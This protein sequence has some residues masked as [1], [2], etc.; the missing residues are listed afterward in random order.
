MAPDR[1]AAWAC[2]CLWSGG[3]G[4]RDG[5]STSGRWT[6]TG[7]RAVQTWSA[8]C[9]V[10]CRHHPSR[11][12]ARPHLRVPRQCQGYRLASKS[13]HRDPRGSSHHPHRMITASRGVPVAPAPGL[14]SWWQVPAY[15]LAILAS[16]GFAVAAVGPMVSRSRRLQGGSRVRSAAA[17]APPDRPRAPHLPGRHRW[18]GSPRRDLLKPTT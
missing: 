16:S 4:D 8:A 9:E 2:N 6:N 17:G 7:R 11:G 14:P 10:G 5:R 1:A 13:D 18:A 15:E 12:R 3:G